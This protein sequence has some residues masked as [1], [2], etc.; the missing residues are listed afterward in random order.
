MNKFDGGQGGGNMGPSGKQSHGGT[1]LNNSSIILNESIKS[2]GNPN[3]I[4]IGSSKPNTTAYM[5]H[6]MGSKKVSPNMYAGGPSG[7]NPS[8]VYQQ[9]HVLAGPSGN[10][11]EVLGVSTQKQKSPSPNRFTEGRTT[12]TGVHRKQ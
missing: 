11:F 7:H 12:A 4:F 6:G 5:T 10:Q 2:S 3:N 9:Q 1:S 8:N